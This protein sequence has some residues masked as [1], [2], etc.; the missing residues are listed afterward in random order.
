MLYF[1]L[2]GSISNATYSGPCSPHTHNAPPLWLWTGQLNIHTLGPYLSRSC[3]VIDHRPSASSDAA[4]A[5]LAPRLPVH[6][7]CLAADTRENLHPCS[8]ISLRRAAG[9]AL[10]A[11]H[12]SGYNM[13]HYP[14]EMRLNG[15][16]SRPSAHY[17]SSLTIHVIRPHPDDHQALPT[18]HP[19]AH[20]HGRSCRDRF[21]DPPRS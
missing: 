20:S 4:A 14:G 16:H 3:C 8:F 5:A 18:H 10:P 19:P 2:V 7:I 15:M 12:L 13:I 6:T 9:S 11:C 21:G 1:S 17:S